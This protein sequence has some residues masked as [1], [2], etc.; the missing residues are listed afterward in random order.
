M[1]MGYVNQ[2]YGPSLEFDHLLPWREEAEFL[3][4]KSVSEMIGGLT[5]RSNGNPWVPADWFV[6][7]F[8]PYLKL[9]R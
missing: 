8:K 2:D 4:D 1:W 7:P 3:F 6:E 5:D 9:G